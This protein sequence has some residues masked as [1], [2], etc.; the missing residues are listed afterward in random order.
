MTCLT[1]SKIARM[2]TM[3]EV[4]VIEGSSKY[5]VIKKTMLGAIVDG[6]MRPTTVDT[7]RI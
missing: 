3:T 1:R 5:S 7:A 6:T 4:T 2:V